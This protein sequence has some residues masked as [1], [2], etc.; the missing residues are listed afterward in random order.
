MKTVLSHGVFDVLHV[1]HIRLLKYA[2]SLG[3]ELVVSLLADKYVKMYKGEKR[4]VHDLEARIEQIKELRCVDRVVVVDGPGHEAVQKMI[5]EVRPAIYV[6]GGEYDGRLLEHDFLH[7]MGV[8]VVF[9][10]MAHDRDAKTAFTKLLKEF[11]D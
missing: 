4:P 5:A 11:R 2:R 1:R 7:A 8:D 6:K 10:E 9:M 3:D